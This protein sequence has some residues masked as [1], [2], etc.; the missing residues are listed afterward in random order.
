MTRKA[1]M[2]EA[3]QRST[4]MPGGSHVVI[5]E[6]YLSCDDRPYA[7]WKV[8]AGTRAERA[9]DGDDVVAEYIDP[10]D[11]EELRS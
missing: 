11:K 4:T 8:R 9:A 7:T 1:A 6:M 2:A 3:W 10:R 5:R